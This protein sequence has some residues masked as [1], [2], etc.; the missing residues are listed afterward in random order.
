MATR[1]LKS[2][3]GNYSHFLTL[4]SRENITA[5]RQED[6]L[7]DEIRRQ[8]KFIRSASQSQV[9]L[10]HSREK[11]VKRLEEQLPSVK[12]KTTKKL[13]IAFPVRN[14]LRREAIT[15]SGVM[16]SFGSKKVLGNI[17]L[18]VM[19][20]E[21]LAIVGVNGAGKTT[22]LRII[23]GELEPDMG[24]ITRSKNLEL[25]WYRQEQD[26]LSDDSTVFDEAASTGFGNQ[27][28]LRSVLA[29]FLFG[30]DRLSQRV[31]TLSRGE[32]ARLALCKIMLKQ[33]NLLLLDEPTNHLDQPSRQS[34]IEALS[35]YK[36][37]IIAVSHDVG[38]LV[39][40]GAEW[41]VSLP[42]GRSVRIE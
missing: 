27:Q 17:S 16:K 24:K 28:V 21:R 20:Q 9:G 30:A 22:L 36:G 6:W 34:L 31:G 8:K 29:H 13:N 7:V 4:R 19:S 32:R 5:Q 41:G 15:V 2:Y 26:N 11:V 14:P 10:K 33:P 1:R 42:D 38:F 39:A 18:E 3:P 12:T 23:A 35:K 40:I 37:A 25:G